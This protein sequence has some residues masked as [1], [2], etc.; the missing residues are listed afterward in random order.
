MHAKAKGK[1]A[2]Q[3]PGPVPNLKKGQAPQHGRKQ[4]TVASSTAT[5]P[6]RKFQ[7]L[8]LQ[9]SLISHRLS[10]NTWLVISLDS[11]LEEEYMVSWANRRLWG[12]DGAWL[13]WFLLYHFELAVVM[14]QTNASIFSIRTQDEIG[15]AHV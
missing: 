9:D 7:T 5:A 11:P 14:Q 6:Q 12:L 13:S 15:R 3:P 8:H 10:S 1:A 2:T 4:G